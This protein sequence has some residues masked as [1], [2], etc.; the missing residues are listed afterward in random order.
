MSIFRGRNIWDILWDN[1]CMWTLKK[2]RIMPHTINIVA[3]RSNASIANY[4]PG[5]IVFCRFGMWLFLFLF[6]KVSWSLYYCLPTRRTPGHLLSASSNVLIF[7]IQAKYLCFVNYRPVYTILHI[8]VHLTGL[9]P[10]WEPLETEQTTKDAPHW[11]PWYN[12]IKNDS[13]F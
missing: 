4:D 8:Y 13:R 9:P 2:E 5:P 1:D 7:L 3:V 6:L 10:S 12:T 11:T